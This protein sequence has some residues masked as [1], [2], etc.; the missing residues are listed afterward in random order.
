MIRDNQQDQ[1][2]PITMDLLTPQKNIELVLVSDDYKKIEQYKSTIDFSKPTELI[3]YGI[4]SQNRLSDFSDILLK[5]VREKNTNEI[6]LIITDLLNNIKHFDQVIHK[7]PFL[8]FFKTKKKEIQHIQTSYYTIQQTLDL[9]IIHLEKQYLYL[10]KGSK[11]FDK[12]YQEN[13]VYYKDLSLYIIAGEETINKFKEEIKNLSLTNTFEQKSFSPEKQTYID[14]KYQ[15][16]RFEKRLLDLKLNLTISLQLAQQ[17]RLIQNNNILLINKIQSIISN[18]LPLW[19]NQI[20]VYLALNQAQQTLKIQ[21]SLTQATDVLV[22]TN[23]QNL[24]DMNVQIA[25]KNNNRSFNLKKINQ[26]LLQ[27]IN[28]VIKIQKEET[29][30]RQ[31]LESNLTNSSSL[32]P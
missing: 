27:T 24:K 6:D 20:A 21:H 19:K 14:L 29:A 9:I 1:D 25:T 28:D 30:S 16:E 11:L 13:E 22:Q 4:A 2:T 12:L 10:L 17:I 31:K 15:L 3:Q 23:N 26:D 32:A 18:T 5:Q 8:F 7:K